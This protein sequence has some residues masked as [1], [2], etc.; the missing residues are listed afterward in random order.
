MYF[1]CYFFNLGGI[2]V[3]FVWYLGGMCVF[4]FGSIFGIFGHFGICIG[5]LASLGWATAHSGRTALPFILRVDLSKSLM[6]SF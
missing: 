2:C 1:G 6:L 3:V 5:T 4:M